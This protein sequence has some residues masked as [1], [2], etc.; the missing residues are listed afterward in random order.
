LLIALR[1]V[2]KMVC[3]A[4]SFKAIVSQAPEPQTYQLTK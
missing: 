3:P 2:C 1:L 4:S